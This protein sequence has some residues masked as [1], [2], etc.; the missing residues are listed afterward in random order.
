MPVDTTRVASPRR[1]QKK[2]T[3]EELKDIDRKR[4]LGKI[5]PNPYLTKHKAMTSARS[6]VNSRALSVDV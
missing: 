3:E 5:Y 4:L 2:L 6:Q 1:T